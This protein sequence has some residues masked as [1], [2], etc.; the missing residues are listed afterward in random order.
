MDK[1]DTEVE[2]IEREGSGERKMGGKSIFTTNTYKQIQ[3]MMSTSV[4]C[5]CLTSHPF[6]LVS[7]VSMNCWFCM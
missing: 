2:G 6:A 4:L 5:N 3:Y 7:H 1:A